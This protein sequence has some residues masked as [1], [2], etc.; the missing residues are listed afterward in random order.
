MLSLDLSGIYCGAPPLPAEIWQRWN[1]D[2][3]LLGLLEKNDPGNQYAV[4]YM[5]GTVLIG[6]FALP[7]EGRAGLF[8]GGDAG[9]LVAQTVAV[10][11]AV[12]F[13]AVVTTAIALVLRGTMGLRVSKEDEER[14]VDLT[15]HDESAYDVGFGGVP[16][17]AEA[18]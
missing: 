18:R 12:V 5:Y 2:P 8:Y 7:D 4:P 9:L 15:L 6:F 11:V 13:T 17:P 10:L 16:V 3:V 1:L 14:G